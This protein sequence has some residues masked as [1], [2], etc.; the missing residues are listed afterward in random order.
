LGKFKLDFKIA[1]M[2]DWEAP[3]SGYLITACLATGHWAGRNAAEYI[4]EKGI[5]PRFGPTISEGVTF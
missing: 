4:L 5:P 2:M 3:T 1:V